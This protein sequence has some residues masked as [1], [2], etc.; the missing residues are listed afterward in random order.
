MTGS[1]EAED[2]RV[3]AGARVFVAVA[4]ALA[5]RCRRDEDGLPI[6]RRA[7]RPHGRTQPGSPA[8]NDEPFPG[9]RI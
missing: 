6:R 4:G 9:T 1:E 8:L 3:L 7:V 5:R 2:V